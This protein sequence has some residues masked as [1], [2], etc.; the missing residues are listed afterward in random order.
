MLELI[1][2]EEFMTFVVAPTILGIILFIFWILGYGKVD[3]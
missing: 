3:K 1:D 2:S